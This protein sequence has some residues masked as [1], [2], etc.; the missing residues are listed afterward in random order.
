MIGIVCDLVHKH[1]PKESNSVQ[2]FGWVLSLSSGHKSGRE[3]EDV[4][5][6]GNTET[7]TSGR[8]SNRRNEFLW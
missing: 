8:R 6:L 3:T 1:N 7:I 2:E 4:R 5:Q